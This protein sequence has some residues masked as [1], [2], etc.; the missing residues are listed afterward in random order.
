MKKIA[1]AD[2]LFIVRE[3]LSQSRLLGNQ[4]RKCGEV[5]LGKRFS[6]ENCGARQMEEKELST[7]GKLYSFTIQ[8]YRPPGD[9]KGPTD[10]FVPFPVGLVELPEG[11]RI[12]AV[13]KDVEKP[14]IGMEL[15]V[16][17]EK[18]FSNAEG[19]EVIGYKFRPTKV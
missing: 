1:I 11:L 12:L 8:R 4:C 2:H 15:E 9:Y 7:K 18:I 10:P 6:C 5:F 17:F 3:P 16:V 14:K 19:D 13:L